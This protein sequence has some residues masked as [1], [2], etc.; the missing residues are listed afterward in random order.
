MN[1][2]AKGQITGA[3]LQR[4]KLVYLGYFTD[5]AH[6]NLHFLNRNHLKTSLH[7]YGEN[8]KD[9]LE[10]LGVEVLLSKQYL[11]Q[12]QVDAAIDKITVEEVS[13]VILVIHFTGH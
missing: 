1:Q 5:G 3:D 2:A 8:S 13:N 6:L 9:L 10:N 11:N 12:R 7:F 4:A